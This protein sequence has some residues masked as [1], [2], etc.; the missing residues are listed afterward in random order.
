MKTQNCYKNCIPSHAL[1]PENILSRAEKILKTLSLTSSVGRPSLDQIR[2]LQGIY[3]L[4]KTG[5]HWKSLPRCFG[6]TSAVHR[7][8]QKLAQE[9]FFKLLWS[10]E[11]EIYNDTHGLSLGKQ[12]MDCAHRKRPLGNEKTGKSPVDR[13]KCGTK[14]SILT[15]N[16]GIVIGMAVGSGNQHDSTLFLETLNSVP[17]VVKQPYCKEMNFDAAYDSETIRIILFNHYYIPKIS[18]NPRRK[19]V[20]LP[21]PLGYS[22]WFVE[23]AHSWMNK[24]RSISTRFCKYAKNYLALAQFAVSV[25]I[26][27]KI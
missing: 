5:A 2:M 19:K 3:Y 18:P 25:I 20:R 11:L 4:L 9:G 7:F 24:F 26:A 14:I 10:K 17:G 21:N 8:F 12:A 13:A 27:N 1:I 23:P 15:D 16:N 6:S 22:R